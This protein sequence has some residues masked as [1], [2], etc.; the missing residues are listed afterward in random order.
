MNTT[1]NSSYESLI[2]NCV[3]GKRVDTFLSSDIGKYLLN[4]ISEDR[5]SFTDKLII[6][7][8]YDTSGIQ[9]LQNSILVVNSIESWL[10]DVLI[11]SMESETMLNELDATH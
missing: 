11:E 9:K 3:F 5:I 4:R 1:Q 8:P 10:A 6:M 2:N 7:D